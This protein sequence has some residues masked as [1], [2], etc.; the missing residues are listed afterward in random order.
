MRRLELPILPDSDPDSFVT[1]AF[2]PPVART[3]MTARHLTSRCGLGAQY[4][5][6]GI[7]CG[8]DRRRVKRVAAQ[9]AITFILM[10]N[11]PCDHLHASSGETG[12]GWRSGFR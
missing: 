5:E 10:A 11:L 9:R 7:E 8:V 2:V 3:P 1:E 4:R 6:S 12:G